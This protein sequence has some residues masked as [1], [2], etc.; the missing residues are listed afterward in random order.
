MKI[1]VTGGT[2]FIGKKITLALLEEGHNLYILTRSKVGKREKDNLKFIEGN[3]AISGDWQDYI[4]ECDLI[5]NLAGETIGQRWN[6]EVKKRIK[7]S[8]INTTK[9]IVDAMPSNKHQTLMST[10]AVGYYGFHEDEE[11]DETF[12]PGDDFLANVAKEWERE[13]LKAKEKGARVVITRFGL[14]IGENGGLLEKLIPIFKNYA[15][16]P[17]GS[18]MQW[19]SWIYIDD[20]IKAYLLL[21]KSKELEGAFNLTSPKPV[22]NKEF[23]KALAKA[24]GVF[25]IFPIPPFAIKFVM[26]EFAEYSIKG[27]RVIPKKLLDLNF[28]FEVPDI[29]DALNR[30]INVKNL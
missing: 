8:R 18:G 12:P 2:G 25:A 5:V 29:Y 14:V 1:F 20:L 4:Q 3:P 16:G 10:S 23:T 30:A 11:I 17:I 13:A 7:E 26:G 15:G 19:F 6:E 9:N 24:L 28:K 22:R 27:Q 21:M